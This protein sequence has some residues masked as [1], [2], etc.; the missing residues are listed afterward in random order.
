MK[1]HRYKNPEAFIYY[2]DTK[3]PIEIPNQYHE[4]GFRALWVSN[5]VNIDLPTI[6]DLKLYQEKIRHMIHTCQSYHIN[7]IFFQVRTNNDAFYAS[8]LNPYSRYFTGSEGQKP[9]FDVL[10]WIIKETKSAGIEFH[11][12]C[13]PYRVSMDGKMSIDAYFET[14]DD[15]NFA[16]KHREHIVLDTRGQ[17]ILNPAKAEVKQHII[18]SMIEL[19]TTYDIDGIHFDDYFYPYAGLSDT[20]NDLPQFKQQDTYKDLG[21]F[22]RAQVTDVI[23]GVHKAL[24]HHAPHIRFGVSPFG[25]YKNR[26]NDP[27]GMNISSKSSQSYDN[28]FADAMLWVKEEMVDYIV[29]QIYWEFG[30]EIAPFADILTWWVDHMKDSKV[31]LYIGHGAYRLGNEGEFENPLEIV[32]QVMFANQFDVVKGNVFFTY[33]T[34]INETQSKAGML[35]LKK[36][37]TKAE[38]DEKN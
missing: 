13:N 12:W 25:I 26:S 28:Q 34:F 31:D 15:L 5:V 38:D 22:R 18:D 20:L 36:L 33:K 9:P 21:D 32:N 17:I 1:L 35:A 37:L 10:A 11:A 30:H 29:P 4:K 23:D 6:E 2:Y 19:A 27:D 14:C 7:A 16:K 3:T 8:K 24:K